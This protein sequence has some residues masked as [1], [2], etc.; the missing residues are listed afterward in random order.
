[1]E[2]KRKFEPLKEIQVTELGDGIWQFAGPPAGFFFYLVVGDESAIL[3]DSGFG[4]GSIMEKIRSITDVPVKL[5]CTHGHP[6][7]G[8]GSAEF[9]DVLLCPADFDVYEQMATREFR[10]K[11]VAHMPGGENFLKILQPTGPAP[12]PVADG[13]EIDLGDRTLKVIYTPGHTHGSICVYDS[14]TH[15]MFT[16]DNVQGFET[17]IREW[18]SSGIDVYVNSL[19]RL[20]EYDISVLYGGHRPNRNDPFQIDKFI[21]CA[22]DLLNGAEGEEKT[23]WNGHTSLTYAKDGVQISYSR[24]KLP[25]R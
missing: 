22:E 23:S 9:E 1:M 20:K 18:N 10:E 24:D 17:A 8:G 13:E 2:G 11:D 12:K 21:A 3:I 5:L 19:K 6:D 4:I 15:A 7:H 25:A 14:L 16:G